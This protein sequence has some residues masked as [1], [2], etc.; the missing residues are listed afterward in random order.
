MGFDHAYFDLAYFNNE[1]F[2]ERLLLSDLFIG[3]RQ[4]YRILTE[5]LILNRVKRD[6]TITGATYVPGIVNNFALSFNGSSDKV[7]ASNYA[8]TNTQP[9]T[10]SC[11]MKLNADGIDSPSSQNF[12]SC[13]YFWFYVRYN[14][15]RVVFRFSDGIS[16][17]EVYYQLGAG[18]RNWHHVVGVYNG[19]KTTSLYVDGILRAGPT[20][21]PN[22]PTS[23]ANGLQIGEVTRNTSFFNG[24]MDEVLIYN[25]ALDATEVSTLYSKGLVYSSL[26]G[27]YSFEESSGT[28]AYDTAPPMDIVYK[29]LIRKLSENV[30]LNDT[31]KINIGKLLNE[32]VKVEDKIYFLKTIIHT[33][34]ESLILRDTANKAIYRGILENLKLSATEANLHI[35]YKNL[36]ELIKLN[37]EYIRL[38]KPTDLLMFADNITSDMLVANNLTPDMLST[39]EVAP[40][41]LETTS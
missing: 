18:D 38:T 35:L 23:N 8:F 10:Y 41:M 1:S 30:R 9:I 37:E 24:S 33:F 22:L 19:N 7:G 5:S 32:I 34:A 14:T 12:L 17:R 25:R 28:I 36:S 39:E 13:N 11:W 4:F 3:T 15:N 2:S 16:A 20:S 40:D 26:V 21:F 6:G 29:S 27:K 31:K